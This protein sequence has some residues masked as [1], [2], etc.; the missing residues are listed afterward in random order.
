MALDN[1]QMQF[2]NTVPATPLID[3]AMEGLG[4]GIDYFMNDVV[5]GG[6]GRMLDAATSELRNMEKSSVAS[7]APNKLSEA[8]GHTPDL[9]PSNSPD[10]SQKGPSQEVAKSMVP[11]RVKEQA[12][13]VGSNG[14]MKVE[15]V[16]ADDIGTLAPAYTP[17]MGASMNQSR[18]IG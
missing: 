17:S 11:E 9:S 14:G 8:K 1:Q 3:K 12:Q 16:A 5:I 18:G 2:A 13:A 15:H 6:A 4:K 10:I 7:L